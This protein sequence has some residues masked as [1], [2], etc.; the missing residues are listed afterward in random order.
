MSKVVKNLRGLKFIVIFAVLRLSILVKGIFQH[1]PRRRGKGGR[2]P[3]GHHFI[4]HH[5]QK[6]GLESPRDFIRGMKSRSL[7]GAWGWGR[8]LLLKSLFYGRVQDMKRAQTATFLIELPLQV[9]WSQERHLRAHLEAARCLYNALLSEANH[10]LRKMHGDPA[11]QAARAIPRIHRLERAQAFSALRKKHHFSEYDLH[12]YAKGARC[13]WI[14]DHIESTMAQTL[15]TRAYQAVNRVALGKAKRVRMRSRGRG[16]DSVEG[17][18]ND[19]GFLI[20]NEQVIPAIIDWLDPVVQHG[21]RHKIK[22]VRLIRRKASSPQ[23]K[24]ADCDGNRYYVQLVLEG[25]AAVKPKHEKPGSDIIGLDIGP[26]TLAIVP[27]EAK[28]SLITF[29]RS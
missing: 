9:D 26:A 19:G 18:R 1:F 4:L 8:T 17:K 29:W 16:I 13:S 11:W 27:R 6:T 3:S 14:A 20:W 22:Y 7:F 2:K 12:E 25:H 24:G 5:L 28:A 21:L 15:A 23:A 10:R